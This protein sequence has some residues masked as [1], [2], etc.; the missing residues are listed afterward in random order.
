LAVGSWQRVGGGG[1]PTANCQ[2]PTQ[3]VVHWPLMHKRVSALLGI[4]LLCASCQKFAEGRQIFHDLLALRDQIATRF[5]EKV[6]DV[7]ISGGDRLTVKFINSPLRSARR[8]EKQQR[9]DDVSA[10]VKSHY[11]HHVSVV[12]TQFVSKSGPVAVNET[13]VGQPQP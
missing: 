6:V 7:N 12:S 3:T 13:F 9:A 4:L 10:F 11:Q 8:E 5:N 2:L 1:L